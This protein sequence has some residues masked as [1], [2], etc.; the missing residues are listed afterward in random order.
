MR[1]WT[2]KNWFLIGLLAAVVLAWLWPEGGRR[3]GTLR[4][5]WTGPAA[6]V[7]IFFLQGLQ[8]STDVLIKGILK[9]RLHLLVQLFIFGLFP[10]AWLLVEGWLAPLVGP[11]LAVGFFFLAV[12][13]TT[14][15]SSAVYTALAGGNSAAAIFNSTLANFAG[16]VLTPLWL[17]GRGF[18]AA[19]ERGLAPVMGEVALLILVPLLCGQVVRPWVRAWAERA[20]KLL[21]NGG[22]ALILFLVYGAFANAAHGGVWRVLDAGVMVWAGLLAL[23]LFAVATG[24]AALIGRR[25]G[26][27]REDRMVLL[28]CGPQKTL[29][30]GVPMANLVFA[31]HPALALVLLPLMLY[32][33]IQL[34]LGGMLLS[35]LKPKT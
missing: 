33:P 15:A 24:G 29:A 35:W 28:F 30:A 32:H 19:A 27:P 26:F 3:G 34:F 20:G 11:D 21:A 25:I 2:R 8:L 7:V 6:V 14:V 17:A 16:V 31:S 23:G 5:E 13:P 1:T 12:L 18:G 4:L 22:S 9:W 10:A